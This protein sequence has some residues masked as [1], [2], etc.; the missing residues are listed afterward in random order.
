MGFAYEVD[1][2]T[3]EMVEHEELGIE[4]PWWTQDLRTSTW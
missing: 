2:E 1:P 4:R 3:Y